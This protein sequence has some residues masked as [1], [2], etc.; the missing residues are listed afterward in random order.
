MRLV[1]IGGVGG[2]MSAA[3]RARRLDE[4]AEIIVLDRGKYVSY[5][6]CGLP[7]RVGGEIPEQ[8]YLLVET[9][10]SL[11]ASLDL[12]VRTEHDVV[13]LDAA[14][15]ELTVMTP[16]GTQTLG[17]DKLI[18]SPG[19][20]AF[21][22]P[23]PGLDASNRVHTLRT[24]EDSADIVEAIESGIR[25]V[26]V[27]GAGFIGLEAAEAFAK[28]G[29]DTTVVELADHVLPPLE[30]EMASIVTTELKRLGIDVRAGI[31]AASIET[32]A[33][34]D[35]VVLSDGTRLGADLILLSVG[36]RPDT[37]VFE[38]AGVATERG[39]IITDE[40]GATNLP[41]VWA[42]GDAVASVDAVTGARRPVALAGPANRAGRLVADAIFAPERARPIPKPVG[43]AIVRVGTLAAGMT[44]ANR[45]SLK[46]AGIEHTTIHLHPAQHV[47]W[48]PGAMT[49]HLLVHFAPDGRIL[50]AQAVGEEGA[51]KRIDVLATAIRAGLHVDDL[52]DFDLA[53]APPY[54]AAKD[55]INMAGMEGEN[56]LTGQ[57]RLWQW[58]QLEEVMEEALLL[59]VRYPYET[60]SGALKGALCIPHKELRGRLDEVREAAAGRPV[61]VYCESGVRSYIAHRVLTEHGFDSATL[62]GGILTLRDGIGARLADLLETPAVAGV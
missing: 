14:A 23:L 43:T 34:E 12:D 24:I 57:T 18:L 40:H 39:A 55:P 15:H 61:R 45:A 6:G 30:T 48:F 38:A 10:E 44:G 35:V 22:P 47:G 21:R 1:V 54:G 50:G 56:V 8:Q 49:V 37:A 11:K 36:V 9:P 29:L 17:Y 3:A 26:V 46:A 42:I 27:L 16:E 28:R 19:A 25:R 31:G 20:V 62:S 13:A 7:Y 2:G 53:Y 60:R 51:D 5:A 41:D 59:D 52:I 4:T 58:T 32:G 33:D